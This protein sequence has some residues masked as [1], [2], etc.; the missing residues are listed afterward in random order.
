MMEAVVTSETSVTLL[1][2]AA[3]H[4]KKTTVF[5]L[6]ALKPGIS[7]T[8]L[9]CLWPGATGYGNSNGSDS[10]AYIQLSGSLTTSR[11]R[12]CPS[13]DSLQSSSSKVCPLY[14]GF[15]SPK[16]KFRHL[17]L[18]SSSVSPRSYSIYPS[19]FGSSPSSRSLWFPF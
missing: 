18:V 3:Q 13:Y 6:V 8:V 2:Y 16:T 19:L 10:H 4:L 9:L 11:T 17:S 1:D 14:I 5:I 7:S 12:D 15:P